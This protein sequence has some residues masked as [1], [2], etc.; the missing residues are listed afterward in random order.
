MESEDPLLGLVVDA[1]EVDRQRIASALR[2]VIVIDKSG[3][4]LP[5]PG[6]Q[7]LGAQQKVLAYLLGRKVAV[8]LE[9]ADQE[10]IGPKDL[11]AS[12][13]LPEGTVYPTVRKLHGE[14]LVSQDVD[15]RYYLSPHQ[16]G[17][18]I[19]ALTVA[20]D[21]GSSGEVDTTRSDAA[22]A[23][24]RSRR[25][26]GAG[27]K[28]PSKKAGSKPRPKANTEEAA[29]QDRKERRRATNSGFS[30]TTAIRELIASGFFDSAKGLGD[31][32]KRFKDKQGRDVA[33]TTLSPILTRLLREGLLD[34]SRNG[35]GIYE[36]VRTP[37]S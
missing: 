25:R 12:S 10:A 23:P 35:N 29:T 24:A 33:V 26:T 9:M 11:A 5:A 15:S 8:L 36:Y 18:A 20:P 19:D 7:L 28:R 34:R 32:Q 17:T 27:K 14:R 16:V 22:P 37:E 3:S 13:G 2:G 1:V 6:Y 4:V 31:I 30:P 21:D